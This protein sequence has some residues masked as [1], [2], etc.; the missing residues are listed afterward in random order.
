[1]AWFDLIKSSLH[2]R[3]VVLTGVPRSG[4]TMVCKLLSDE[5]DCIALNEPIRL[6]QA[7][8]RE[9]V[10][11]MTRSFYIKTRRTLLK[12]GWAYAKAAPD[13]LVTNHFG[14]RDSSG[15]REKL[16]SRRRV[17]FGK[18]LSPD[19]WLF[20]KHN[21]AFTLALRELMDDFKIFA[22]IREPLAVLLSWNSVDIPV[23]KGR[24]RKNFNQLLGGDERLQ[25]D[26]LFVRQVGLLDWYF[27]T[28]RAL[29]KEHVLRYE[30]VVGSSGKNLSIMID[31]DLEQEHDLSSRN[32]SS[33]YEDELKGKLREALLTYGETCWQFYDKREYTS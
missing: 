5:R 14:E 27:E 26:D 9:E 15:K 32:R 28:Y 11:K 12:E 21:A 3:D 16:I 23:S 13:G 20:V 31:R 29:S 24:L 30:D 17:D 7:N 18:G 2:P 4:T 19:F 25:S 33:N 22:T 10:L 8:S 6:G 1:M